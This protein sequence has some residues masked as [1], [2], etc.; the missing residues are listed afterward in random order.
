M[1]D[2]NNEINLDGAVKIAHGLLERPVQAVRPH[3]RR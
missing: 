2:D 3:T 1:A